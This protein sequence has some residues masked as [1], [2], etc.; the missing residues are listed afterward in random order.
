MAEIKIDSSKEAVAVEIT[1]LF[2][3][4][5]KE[6]RREH[7]SSLTILARG[8]PTVAINGDVYGDVR[9]GNDLTC[10]DIDGNAKAGAEIHAGDIS[11]DARAGVDLHA[12]DIDGNA[13]AGADIHCGDISGN[14]KAGADIDCNYVAGSV[15]AGGEIASAGFGED[16]E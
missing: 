9:A 2:K 1:V 5:A 13:S 8:T 15:T 14:A 10:R 11:G 6:V 4:G 3:G 7:D 16:E 12:S